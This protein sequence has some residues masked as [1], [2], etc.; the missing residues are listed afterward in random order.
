MESTESKE[1]N[2]KGLATTTNSSKDV[3]HMPSLTAFLKP[4]ADYAGIA[5]RDYVKEKVEN[6]KAKKRKKNVQQHM[7]SVGVILGEPLNYDEESIGSIKQLDLFDEWLDGAQDIDLEDE[8]LAKLW[9]GLLLEIVQGKSKNR[10]LISTLKQLESHEVELLLNFNKRRVF[11]PKDSESRFILKKLKKLELIESDLSY[12][13]LIGVSYVMMIALFIS[14][15]SF[16]MF[17][18]EK[19]NAVQLGLISIIPVA[20]IY[21]RLPKYKASWLGKRLLNTAPKSP[22]SPKTDKNA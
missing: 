17:F 4:T 15:P 11:H 1:S 13:T 16:E 21:S 20:A 19:I 3:S 6:L 9:Q 7:E 2:G 22:K 5:L 12:L 18:S 8:T 14:M 10:L